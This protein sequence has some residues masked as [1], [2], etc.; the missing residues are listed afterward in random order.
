[1]KIALCFSGLPRF[2]EQTSENLYN[3]L[4]QNYDVDVFVHT[5]YEPGKLMRDCGATE[6]SNYSFT[7][8]PT[9]MIKSLYNVKSILVESS[10]DFFSNSILRTYDSKPTL[11]KYMPHFLNEQGERYYIN[12]AHSMWYSIFQSN[13]L[14]YQYE[15]TNNMLYDIVI[16]CRF[17]EIL[18]GPIQFENFNLDKINV[19]H[20]C[21][22]PEFPYVRDWFAFSNS[23]NMNVYADVINNLTYINTQIPDSERMNERF[24]YQQLHDNNLSDVECYNFHK[25]FIRP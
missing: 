7:T 21:D 12:A 23:K 24:L 16:R 22:T 14:K 3:N 1:M 10:K 5:W 8:D 2:V 17:D 6:W 18:T 15:I 11:E 9:D 25:D 19:S 13:Q 4:I 20:C